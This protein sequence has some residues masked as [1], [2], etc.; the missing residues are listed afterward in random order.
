M[1][2]S[3]QVKRSIAK[4]YAKALFLLCK[5]DS[6]YDEVERFI[7]SLEDICTN[8]EEFVSFIQNPAISRSQLQKVLSEISTRLKAGERLK[9]FCD[10]LAKHRRI[11][12]L[13]EICVEFKALCAEMRGEVCAT[14]IS[15]DKLAA[16]QISS[17]EDSLGKAL[18]KKVTV[19]NDLDSTIIGGLIIKVGSLML[20]DSVKAKLQALR[21]VSKRAV[22]AL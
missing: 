19:K 5:E 17:I 8:S 1:G 10:V 12:V 6:S 13:P 15:K 4:R 14:V 2:S 22:A 7:T 21:M 3:R 16:K 18:G 9:Q 11:S 20:D